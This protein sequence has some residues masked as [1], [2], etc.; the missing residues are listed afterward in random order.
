MGSV[1]ELIALFY[2]RDFHGI[3]IDETDNELIQLFRYCFVGGGAFLVDFSTYCVLI[4]A[5]LNYLVSGVLSFLLSFAFNFLLSRWFVFKNAHSEKIQ[6]KELILVCAIS[7][8][9]LLITECLLF[10]L[11]HLLHTGYQLSKII[12]SIIV[13]IWNY[14]ARKKLVY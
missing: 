6:S 5:G 14:C 12:A 2:K 3:F 11:T 1:K 13:L 9:G 7:V 10:G 4:W 8:I